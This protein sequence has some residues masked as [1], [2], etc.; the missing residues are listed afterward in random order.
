MKTQPNI[1]VVGQVLLDT[2]MSASDGEPMIRLG[3]VMHAARALWAI[4]CPFALYYFAPD[5][6][7]AHISDYTAQL[8]CRQTVK[9]GNVTGSPNVVVVGVPKEYGPQKYEYLLREEHKVI[10]DRQTLSTATKANSYTDALIFPGGY[11][12]MAVLHAISGNDIR[13]YLDVNFEPTDWSVLSKLSRGVETI[14]VSTS[15][16]LFTSGKV[17]NGQGI[18]KLA[19][20]AKANS[21]LLKENRGGCRLFLLKAEDSISVGAQTRQVAHSVGVGDCFDAIF[22]AERHAC[23]DR[24]ALSYASF[25][26]AVYASTFLP[27]VFKG[28]AKRWLKVR[29]NSISAIQG[30]QLPWEDRPLHQIYVAAPDFD[31]VDTSPL[32]ALIASLKYHNFSP[33]RPVKEHGQLTSTTTAAE[34]QAVFAKDMNLLADCSLLLAVLLYDD[35]GT[36]IEIGI[37]AQRGLPVIVYD[38]YRKATNLILTELPYLVSSDLDTIITGVFE[39]IAE[40]NGK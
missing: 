5:Y 22:I 26:S 32:E 33:R 27:D 24:A 1:L 23:G 39:K 14:I 4:G 3:G 11:D 28:N 9:I 35:P 31:Y 8:G 21:V 6:L 25:I 36:L 7:D 34:R 20:K 37:A 16:N 19:A 38:P 18:I 30:T 12:L 2:L 17:N 40:R 10:I 15:S 13:I 29:A